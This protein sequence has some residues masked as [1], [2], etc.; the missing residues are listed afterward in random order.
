MNRM[1]E[2]TEENL[3]G[4]YEAF[5]TAGNY[6]VM[7]HPGFTVIR[8]QKSVFPGNVYRLDPGMNEASFLELV[9]LIRN[10]QAPPFLIFR[11]ETA[12]P[13]FISRLKSGGFRQ[14]MQWPGMAVD[15]ARLPAQE[16]VQ[17]TTAVIKKI[18]T[19]DEINDWACIVEQC[20]FNNG[21]LDRDALKNLVGTGDCSLYVGFVDG[22]A[23]GTMLSF[24]DK[25]VT[26]FYMLATLPGWRKKGVARKLL[27]S[28]LRDAVSS[29]SKYA[30][31]EATP[32]GLSLYRKAGFKEYC[33]FGIYWML[34]KN[35]YHA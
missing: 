10:G 34:G 30:V 2:I 21:R 4:L 3:F 20:L 18:S 12:P 28:A 29:G 17:D 15:L 27:R 14:V 8:K 11:T 19:A 13:S 35:N 5:A 25:Q 33:N 23:I 6:S 24:C 9:S 1:P 7:Q 32:Q 31:L 16:E 22:K 26:G